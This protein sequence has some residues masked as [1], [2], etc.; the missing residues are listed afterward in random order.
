MPE[1]IRYPVVRPEG[2]E[3]PTYSS[4]GCRSIQLSYGRVLQ[5]C[6]RFQAPLQSAALTPNLQLSR[7]RRDKLRLPLYLYEYATRGVVDQLSPCRLWR[8]EISSHF[9]GTDY[10]RVPLRNAF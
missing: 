9:C 2:V 3:P 7:L 10:G 4:V 8:R 5:L 6:K 1:D